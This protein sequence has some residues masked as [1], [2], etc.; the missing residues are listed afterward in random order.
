MTE[1]KNKHF[2]ISEKLLEQHMEKKMQPNDWHVVQRVYVAGM[3][4]LFS[5]QTH[6]Q[7][8]QEFIKGV[9]D[10]PGHNIGDILGTDMAHIMMILFAES[11]NT[12]PPIAIIPAT[13][14][15]TAKVCEFLNHT[16]ILPITD[17]GFSDAVHM[18]STVLQSKLDPSFNKRIGMQQQQ[19]PAAAPAQPQPAPVQP[20]GMLA[21]GA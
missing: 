13:T 11:K 17:K 20:G 12:M 2:T 10:N 19:A 8:L 15:L 18:A 4:L 7:L 9:Q 14:L 21:Q 1:I 5:Q 3:Q 16:G 6:N